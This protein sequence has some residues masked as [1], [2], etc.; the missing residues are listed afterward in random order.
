MGK[1]ALGQAFLQVIQ[2]SYQYHST[3]ALHIHTGD[4]Q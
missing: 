4:E 2:F 3:I 1:V